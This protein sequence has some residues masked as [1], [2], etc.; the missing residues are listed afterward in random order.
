M[1]K[2]AG[3][4]GDGRKGI[5]FRSAQCVP[6][7]GSHLAPQAPPAGVRASPPF[8][9][10]HRVLL[11]APLAASPSRWPPQIFSLHIDVCWRDSL[12]PCPSFILR[13][14]TSL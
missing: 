7:P 2:L 1:T 6:W 10:R 13:I 5:P 8:A 11:G 4:G 14:H 12:V 3:W 9:L